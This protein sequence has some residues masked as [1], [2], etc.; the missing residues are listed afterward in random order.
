VVKRISHSNA[1]SYPTE[2]RGTAVG[3]VSAVGKIGGVG[4]PIFAGALLGSSVSIV[5]VFLY[6]VTPLALGAAA[7]LLLR[8]RNIPAP[9]R[10]AAVAD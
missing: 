9:G 4:G 3:A 1:I 7:I 6:A 5:W 8:A 10:V 2:M